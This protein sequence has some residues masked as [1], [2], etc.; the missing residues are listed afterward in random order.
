VKLHDATVL[1]YLL[2]A[3]PGL[4]FVIKFLGSS[5]SI[6]MVSDPEYLNFSDPDELDTD[7]GSRF[8]WNRWVVF[9]SPVGILLFS[10]WYFGC[11]RLHRDIVCSRST[12]NPGGL[13]RFFVTNENLY[14]SNPSIIFH[15]SECIRNLDSNQEI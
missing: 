13:C 12:V 5:F 9:G 4:R 1:Q 15:L 7:P 10:A 3:G 8:C 11:C 2:C 14:Y 6:C